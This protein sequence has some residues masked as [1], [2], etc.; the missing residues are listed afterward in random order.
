MST[1]ANRRQ[2]LL[3]TAAA[4]TVPM[5]F[6]GR[7]AFAADHDQVIIRVDTD[8]GNLDPA[9]RTGSTEDDILFAVC[10]NL[11]RLNPDCSLDGTFNPG[12]GA[13]DRW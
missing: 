10:Q 7:P 11:A 6:R 1:F 9:N 3:G 5:L 4:A 8:I 13:S 2:F 12:T